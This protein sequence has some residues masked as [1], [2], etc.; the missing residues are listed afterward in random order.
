MD[1]SPI[2]EQKAEYPSFGPC[3]STCDR[4][5]ISNTSWR[6]GKEYFLKA[7]LS[8]SRMW[9]FGYIV[10][11]A[12]S[13]LRLEREISDR[14][15]RDAFEDLLALNAGRDMIR[16]E[17]RRAED[18]K[19]AETR[20]Q[21]TNDFIQ[22]S[23]MMQSQRLKFQAKTMKQRRTY[24]EDGET[25][26]VALLDKGLLPYLKSEIKASIAAAQKVKTAFEA[27]RNAKASHLKPPGHWMT[28]LITNGTAP[29]WSSLMRNSVDGPVISFSRNSAPPEP[30]I[31]MAFSE[32]EL[33]ET[34]EGREL[35]LGEPAALPSRLV[36]QVTNDSFHMKTG[37]VAVG[38]IRRYRPSPSSILVQH[39]YAEP[40]TLRDGSIGA[41]AYIKNQL[42]DRQVE[43]KEF[44][45]EPGMVSEE[46]DLARQLMATVGEI[47]VNRMHGPRTDSEEMMDRLLESPD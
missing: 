43:V 30:H 15:W 27:Q 28:S 25:K 10:D 18:D 31:G 32:R 26:K 8:S 33:E 13:P 45:E 1:Y 40:I 44:V 12:Y 17:S 14:N 39:A 47:V 9:P 37:R 46:M 4:P 11:S 42:A 36:D 7:Y 6:D 20:Y 34:F 22:T 5:D 29:G 41:K 38:L 21:Y 2:S 35:Q 3:C 19:A 24:V 23:N 16:P